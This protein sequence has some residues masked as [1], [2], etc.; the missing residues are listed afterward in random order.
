MLCAFY[1]TSLIVFIRQIGPNR[2]VHR[3]LLVPALKR[4]LGGGGEPDET[5]YTNG[6]HDVQVSIKPRALGQP[7]GTVVK[8]ALS[9]PAT[10]SS[11]VWVLGVT[12]CTACQAMLWQASHI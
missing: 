7:G 1:V 9:A 2:L 8:F 5:F 3:C 6:S 11:P 4:G 10:R 12:L